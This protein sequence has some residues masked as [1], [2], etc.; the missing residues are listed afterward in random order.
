MG[1]D[2]ASVAMAEPSSEALEGAKADQFSGPQLLITAA[3]SFP[4]LE[5]VVLGAKDRIVASFRVFDPQTKLRS[6]EARRVGETWADLIASTLRRGVRV[7][8]TVADFDPVARFESHKAT[9]RAI[10]GLKES[11]KR[12]G[13]DDL[14]EATA[15]L[16]PARAGKVLQLMLNP[17][18]RSYLR[19]IVGSLNRLDPAARKE[20]LD[21]SPGVARLLRQRDDG[22]VAVKPWCVHALAPAT[23]HQKMLVA[24]GETLY[25][26]GLDLDDRRY[27]DKDHRR[28]AV[29]TWHDVQVILQGEV[30]AEAEAHIRSF[31]A[32]TEGRSTPARMGHL[33]RTLSS[34]RS[35]LSQS[36]GPKPVIAEIQDRHLDEV[37]RAERLIY[38]ESQFF[39]DRALADAL[40]RRAQSAPDL[41]LIALLPAAPEEAVSGRTIGLDVKFGEDL[42]SDCV[43]QV[44]EAFG[45]RAVFIA[46]ALPRVAPPDGTRA[47][48]H[49]APIIYVHAKVSIFDDNC[50][51]ISSANLNG[52]SFRWD[53][54]AGVALTGKQIVSDSRRRLM[55]H[56]LPENAAPSFYDEATSVSSWRTLAETNRDKPPLERSGF[57]LPLPIEKARR[58]GKS[59]PFLPE[60][61]A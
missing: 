37:S 6:T 40:C 29:E 10:R 3:E 22:T 14:L 38:L 36:I 59:I 15:A 7:S 56:W 9:H 8:I 45:D 2:N 52:R 30:A 47:V 34:R 43:D 44:M 1:S 31:R 33:L 17:M 13:R 39:R 55:S 16:H 23:H 42:Q 20:S 57:L 58:A 50:A 26:G 5:R 12:S 41:K 19:D 48:L 25:I 53:T 4:A 32:E 27:D 18:V 60:E 49:A 51:I 28:P 46:P 35:T 11:G 24:D 54:E 61:M 21:L